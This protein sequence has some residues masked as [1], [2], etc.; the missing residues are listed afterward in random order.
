MT[1]YPAPFLGVKH[2]DAFFFFAVDQLKSPAVYA[3]LLATLE[4][5]FLFLSFMNLIYPFV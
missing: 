2:R 3:D 5:S 4:V 1:V